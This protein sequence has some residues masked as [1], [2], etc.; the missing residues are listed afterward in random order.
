M[1]K[2]AFHG[3]ALRV[4]VIGAGPAGFYA[5][6]ELLRLDIGAVDLYE[7]LFAPYGLVRY[8]VAPDHQKTKL[9]T[10]RY[11]KLANEGFR[12]IGNVEIGVT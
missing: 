4:A 11:D 12:F 3:R 7:R 8:G 10:K 1:V 2:G 5:A 9:V 6:E